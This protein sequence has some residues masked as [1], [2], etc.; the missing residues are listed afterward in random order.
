LSRLCEGNETGQ[1]RDMK[2]SVILPTYNEAKNIVRLITEVR[3]CVPDPWQCEIIVVDDNSSDGTFAAVE[4]SFS[5][6]SSVKT[7][8]RTSDRGLA[9]SIRAGIDQAQGDY[10][11]VMDT[12]FTHRPEEIPLMLHV[13]QK[14][15]L[16]SGSRF[17]AG[18]RMHNTT[19][20]LASFV[21]NLLIRVMIRTQIQDNLGGFWV[22]RADRIRALPFDAIFFG[23]GDYY[24]RLLHY[25]QAIG[26]TVVELPSFYSARAG[27]MSKSNFLRLLFTYSGKLFALMLKNRT[28]R[29]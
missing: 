14:V 10:L 24:F 23:Y 12:D 19:H 4:S 27:G 16:V 29:S 18:G 1:R 21:Y 9:N 28:I 22:A 6:D 11:L 25:A 15:D 20:Y 5:G 2:V 7:I 17:S 8:L 26:M 13:V 3:A